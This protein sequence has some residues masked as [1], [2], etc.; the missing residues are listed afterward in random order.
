MFSPFSKIKIIQSLIANNHANT[1]IDSADIKLYINNTIF[2][3]V[4]DNDDSTSIKLENRA[5]LL[6]Y[7]SN[8]VNNIGNNIISGKIM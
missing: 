4:L 6:I 7:D 1:I 3:N 5:I 8:V 2:N